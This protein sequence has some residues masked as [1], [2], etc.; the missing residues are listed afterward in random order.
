MR[1]VGL[2]PEANVRT[3]G[4]IRWRSRSCRSPSRSPNEARDAVARLFDLLQA[5]RV[6]G[7]DVTAAPLAERAARHRD[8]LLVEQEALRE[9]LVVHPGRGDV[10]EAVERAARLE[11]VQPEFVE[12]LEH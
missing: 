6:A 8:D 2:R 5:R 7:A 1:R 10:R 3:A 12:P 4:A 9:L 11:A